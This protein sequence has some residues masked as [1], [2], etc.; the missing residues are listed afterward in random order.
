VLEP[1]GSY[2]GT[3]SESAVSACESKSGTTA[4]SRANSIQSIGAIGGNSV[5]VLR[6]VCRDFPHSIHLVFVAQYLGHREL[7]GGCGG[8]DLAIY[9]QI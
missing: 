9:A 7:V 6:A 8:E 3:R 1:G 4:K 5:W 2:G